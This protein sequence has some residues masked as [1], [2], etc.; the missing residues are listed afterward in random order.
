MVGILLLLLPWIIF[1]F[2]TDFDLLFQYFILKYFPFV[3][4]L[5]RKWT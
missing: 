4:F 3:Y 2:A 5:L 1:S